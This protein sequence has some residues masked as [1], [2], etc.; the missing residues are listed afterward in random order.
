MIE[1]FRVCDELFCYLHT[2]HVRNQ[3]SVCVRLSA[4]SWL[5]VWISCNVCGIHLRFLPWS[6]QYAV[7][8]PRW[9]HDMFE[10][11]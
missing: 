3:T 2:L 9:Q 5:H 7:G 8:V 4:G 11:P 10:S 1:A 6:C